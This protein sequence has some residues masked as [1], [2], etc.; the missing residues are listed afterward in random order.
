M[1]DGLTDEER[2]V[3]GYD[4]KYYQMKFTNKGGLPMPIILEFIFEDGSKE[5]H[6]IPAEIWKMDDL[7][8]SKVFYSKKELKEVILDPNT[9]TADVDRSD[10]Y[11]PAK[12]AA[13]QVRVVQVPRTLFPWRCIEPDAEGEGVAAFGGGD[14][15]W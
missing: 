3:L 6:F 8:V 14:G 11:W 15:N 1:L 12:N 5:R 2:E 7:Q 9:Q 13:E 4:W 10:N